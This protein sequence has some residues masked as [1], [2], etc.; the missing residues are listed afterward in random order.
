MQDNSRIN[1][2]G[3]TFCSWNIRGA[4]EPIKRGKILAQL[5]SLNMDIAFLQE[6]HLKQQTQI[7]LRAN[8]IG[9]TYYSSFTSKARGTAIIIRKGIPFKLKNSIS[10]KEGRYVI[11]TGEIYNTPLTMINIY[12]PNFDNPQFF[13]KIIDL[14]AEHNF[15][16]IIMGGDFNC[17]IDPYL[18]KSIKLGKRLVKTKTCEFLNTYIKNNNIADVWRIANPSGR[19]YSFYSSVHKTYSRIDYFLLDTKLIPYTNKPSYHNSI[20]S[21][22]S[23]LTFILKIEGMPS[24]KPFWRF[25]AHILNNPQGYEYIKEQTKLFFEINDTPGISA[26]LLW[27]TFK[28]YIRGVIISYQSFQNKENKRELQRIEQKI[29]LLELDNAT[30]PTIN[31]HNKITLLKYKV[32]RILSARVIRLFQ[33]TKQAHFEFGDKPHKLLARQL[34][35]REKEKKL[36]QKLN[37]TMVSF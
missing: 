16:N 19:E 10:D 4:N 18:D 5:K 34:K 8:W 35:Q 14:I 26:P 21:D 33:I 3:L 11:V 1:I 29:K 23:P 27:E 32:N 28:A 13:R 22:H 31:K 24:I 37:R 15:Q 6:T 9:Q 12:A 17:V 36:L 2:G 30:D 7:R 25:N 20:I